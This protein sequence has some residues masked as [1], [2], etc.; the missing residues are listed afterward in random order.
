MLFDGTETDWGA[1]RA[2]GDF[3]AYGTIAGAAAVPRLKDLLEPRGVFRR[4]VSADV[5]ASALFAL[6]KVRNDDARRVIEGLTVDKEPVVRSAANT[7]LRDWS[8]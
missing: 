5:R 2:P 8:E 6:V 1:H 7:A 3:R 4:R